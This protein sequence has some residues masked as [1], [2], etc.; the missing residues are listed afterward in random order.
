[1]AVIFFVPGGQDTKNEEIWQVVVRESEEEEFD[2]PAGFNLVDINEN[3]FRNYVSRIQH[4]INEEISGQMEKRLVG[5]VK[6]D[7]DYSASNQEDGLESA[8]NVWKVLIRETVE[9]DFDVPDG[10]TLVD[11]NEDNFGNYVSRIKHLI[12]DEIAGKMENGLVGFAQS[13]SSNIVSQSEE[14]EPQQRSKLLKVYKG[15]MKWMMNTVVFD[16]LK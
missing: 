8:A 5:F 16:V 2:I 3:N 4:L 13:D 15:E 10:F 12:N 1:M 14:E 7:P 11:I 9:E 6:S